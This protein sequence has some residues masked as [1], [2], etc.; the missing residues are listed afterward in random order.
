MI[1]LTTGLP[2]DGKTLRTLSLVKMIS[3]RDSRPVFYSG[4]A[5]LNLPWTEIESKKWMECPPNSIVVID[6]CQKDFG[7]RALSKEVPEHIAKLA[8]HRHGGIDIY[9]IT[10]HPM[11]LDSFV[12]RLVNSHFHV[13]RPFG[14]Q[15]CTVHEWHS[16]KDNCDKPAAR[17]DSTKHY[18]KYDVTAFDY[19]KSAELHTVKR[20]IPMKLY[21]TLLIPLI[22]VLCGYY[23]YGFMQKSKTAVKEEQSSSSSPSVV[24]SAPTTSSSGRASYKNAFD[25]AK[26]FVFASQARIEGLPFTAPKYDEITKPI[27]APVPAG[28]VATKSRCSCYTQ[29]ATPIKMP[30][31]ICLDIVKNGYFQDF[32][33]RGKR[34]DERQKVDY[35]M[36]KKTENS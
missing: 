20:S 36:P 19:Y 25:D 8:T 26:E 1:V 33:S 14:V 3:E 22:L 15:A 23:L 29:Q 34:S 4:I 32:D 35:S 28:C 24:P 17:Q 13:V 30:D 27:V 6:E 5:D 16:I 11:L 21:L 9:F 2:G 7:V 12:R 18:W 10:Q 31:E